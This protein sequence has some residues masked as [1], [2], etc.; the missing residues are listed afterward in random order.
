MSD[1]NLLTCHTCRLDVSVDGQS[2]SQLKCPQ[3]GASLHQ[4]VTESKE[5]TIPA[6]QTCS[7]KNNEH[8]SESALAN[9][10][11]RRQ[12]DEFSEFEEQAT[13]EENATE[14]H[15]QSIP[16]KLA[17]PLED[18]HSDRIVLEQGV[19]Q[20]VGI[21]HPAPQKMTLLEPFGKLT[22]LKH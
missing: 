13:M 12:A 3:C 21:N 1:P 16:E 14:Q 5:N 9:P 6:D 17:K 18:E 19:G 11:G 2:P 22:S 7:P 10:S 20:T 4:K 15:D 8:T